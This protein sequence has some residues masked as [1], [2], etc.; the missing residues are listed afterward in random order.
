[1]A[2]LERLPQNPAELASIRAQQV[3]MSNT[4]FVNTTAEERVLAELDYAA[5]TLGF[6]GRPYF[7]QSGR[8]LSIP[9]GWD[10]GENVEY[11]DFMG[12]SFEGEFVSYGKVAVGRIIG[13]R[14][15]RALCMAFKDVTTLPN[16]RT[17]PDDHLFY[18]PVLA[19]ESITNYQ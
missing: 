4:E 7:I 2:V 5:G 19:V 9:V 11:Q 12:V 15:V 17:I 16:F 18:T 3:G 8:G 10:D 14:V 13:H 1:M 6:L